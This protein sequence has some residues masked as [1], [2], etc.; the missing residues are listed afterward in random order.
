L[1][2][3]RERKRGRGWRKHLIPVVIWNKGE[4]KGVLRL[5]EGMMMRRENSLSL[6]HWRNF[7]EMNPPF[8]LPG[9]LLCVSSPLIFRLLSKQYNHRGRENKE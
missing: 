4:G 6:F 5:Q 7:P 8:L 2:L 9:F 1:G 3:G